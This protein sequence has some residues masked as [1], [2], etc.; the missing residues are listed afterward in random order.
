[1]AERGA[2][3]HRQFVGYSF[4]RVQPE[5]RRLPAAERERGRSEFAAVFDEYRP[6][7]FLRSYSV[8]GTRADSDLMLWK[9]A[10]EL[11]IFNRFEGDLNQ[12][13]LGGYLE[14]PYSLL[15]ATRRST[16]LAEGAD[17]DRHGARLDMKAGRGKYLFVYPFVKQRAWYSLAKQER[18]TMMNEHFKI[19]AAYPEFEVNT[20]YSFGLDDQEFV[21][22]FEGDQ[23]HRFVDLVMELRE[24]RA[25][26]YTER[27]TPIFTCIATPIAEALE[28]L[29]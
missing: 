15:S 21:V 23:P 1:M 2:N 17:G 16:Y 5:W 12:T 29:G 3:G 8:V 24:S 22:S 18:Q 4:Y 14:R 25:S 26:A 13:L 9:A 11:E 28:L 7:I 27:D 20:A 19:G 10:H 6:L